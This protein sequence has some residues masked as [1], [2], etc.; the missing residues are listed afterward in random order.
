ME[1]AEKWGVIRATCET[2]HDCAYNLNNPQSVFCELFK[3][4]VG[5]SKP[6]DIL[7]DGADCSF[8]VTIE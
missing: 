3:E 5:N 1:H 8:K 2:C 7:Y 6:H 4:E